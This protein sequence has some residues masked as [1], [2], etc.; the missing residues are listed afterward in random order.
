MV[1]Y[2]L[3]ISVMYYDPGSRPTTN[4]IV[5]A[6]YHCCLIS[7]ALLF[8]EILAGADDLQRFLGPSEAPKNLAQ[9]LYLRE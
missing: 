7:L 1:P 8:I 3:F 6:L 2:L 4:D 5:F 9:D